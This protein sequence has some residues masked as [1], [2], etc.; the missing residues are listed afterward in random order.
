[1]AT[2]YDAPRKNDDDTE[3]LEAIKDRIPEGTTASS[4]VDD[5]D[6]SDSFAIPEVA[7]E[8]LDV[9]VVPKQED[10][11]TCSEC[12]IVKHHSQKARK[13]GQYGPVCVDCS[14]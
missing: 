8:E 4:D 9:V 11:F 2:D 1:M 10:E 5:A 3:S 13:D 6:H 7:N 14:N 12:F